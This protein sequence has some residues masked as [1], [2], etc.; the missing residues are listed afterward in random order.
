MKILSLDL[1]LNQATSGAKIIEIGAC[2]GDLNTSSIIE[3]YTAFVNPHEQLLDTI[4]QLTSITQEQVDNAGTIEDA[5]AGMVAM[6]KRHACLRMPIVWGMGDGPAIRRELP[7][8]CKWKFG[9]RELDV[10][11]LF[12]S[13]QMAKGNKVHAE[14]ST[15]MTHLGLSFT[16]RQHRADD[17]A[18]NT[19][20][21]FSELIKKFHG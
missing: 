1:E 4:I 20:I 12:Q 10:K 5:Y 2:V 6:A 13:Y 7:S 17:D 8:T 15:A 9:R 3:R 14:L 18:I 16:G 19:F 11:A 21:I